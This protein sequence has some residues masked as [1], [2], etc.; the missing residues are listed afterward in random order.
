MKRK[1]IGMALALSLVCTACAGC[2]EKTD[3]TSVSESEVSV[4]EETTS[5]EVTESVSEETVEAEPLELTFDYPGGENIADFDAT[6]MLDVNKFEQFSGPITMVFDIDVLNDGEADWYEINFMTDYDTCGYYRN[7]DKYTVSLNDYIGQHADIEVPLTEEDVAEIKDAGEM[8]LCGLGYKINSVT[9]KG[10]KNP[11]YVEPTAPDNSP[12]SLHGQLSIKDGGFVDENGEKLRLLGAAMGWNVMEPMFVNTTTYSYLRDDWG[13]NCVRM[14]LEATVPYDSIGYMDEYA[15]RDY[16][17]YFLDMK[18]DT[19]IE[20][21]LYAVVCYHNYYNI[22]DTLEGAEA[23][24]T[25]VCEK[26]GDCPNIIYEIGNEPSGDDNTA[27]WAEVKEYADVIIPLIRSYN[28]D[29]VIVCPT[30][31]WGCALEEDYNDP[32]AYDNVIYNYHLY[33]N[34]FSQEELDKVAGILAD[35]FPV[36]LTEYSSCGANNEPNDFEGT[37]KWE[38]VLD[39]Y[40]VSYIYHNIKPNYSDDDKSE[41][42]GLTPTASTLWNWTEDDMGDAMEYFYH[43]FRHDSGLE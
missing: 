32:L 39:E 13:L 21:G 35:G 4:S 18:I 29:A 36:F 19:C 22:N 40:G 11:D 30:P 43:N 3:N 7:F 28:P 14:S 42:I 31:G 41:I 25:H 33:V 8:I 6:L 24:F 38:E 20:T 27:T 16:W 10:T 26:Y 2:G 23:F 37:A 17:N 9:F 12:V 34:E 15:N 1:L 5:V